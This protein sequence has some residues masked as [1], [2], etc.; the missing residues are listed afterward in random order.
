LVYAETGEI[1]YGHNIRIEREPA[2][3]TKV[4]T[5]LLALEYAAGYGSL[6]DLITAQASDLAEVRADSSASNAGIKEGEVMTLQDLIYC[7]MLVSANEACNMIARH[8]GGTVADFVQMMNER[9]AEIGCE[10]T[11]F[12]NPH[13]LPA[14]GHIST[15]YDLSLI[16]G[17]ALK[18]EM[19]MT[20]VNTETIP[21]PGTAETPDGRVLT[22]DMVV[23]F[24]RTD[25]YNSGVYVYTHARGIKTG[26]SSS[27][28]FCL[29][30]A[31]EKGGI[32]L[33]SVVLGAEDVRG[34][35][36]ITYRRSFTETRDLFEWGYNNFEMKRILG[37]S[38]KIHGIRVSM[39][40]DHDEIYLIPERPSEILLPKYINPGDIERKVVLHEPYLSGGVIAPVKKERVLGE[41]ILLYGGTV[42]DTVP[43]VSDKDV[44]ENTIE[45]VQHRVKSIVTSKGF[46]WSVI[47]LVGLVGGY[48][49]FVIF[50]NRRRRHMRSG[51]YRG[52]RKKY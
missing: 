10:N 32:A 3:L 21:L 27:A 52:G 50:F 1:L 30:S 49:V 12:T 6:N 2:S 43:L 20:V 40:L 7:A 13:G 8:V 22:S 48:A 36:N 37:K 14:A 35:D 17:E 26:A 4:M 31:A 45:K 51:N 19:L 41:V 38:D 18:N 44:S 16:A 33:I 47:V 42:L 24:R 9:A 46:I 25:R 23:R 29:M 34:S 11:N 5:V 28:G 15:A 39:G